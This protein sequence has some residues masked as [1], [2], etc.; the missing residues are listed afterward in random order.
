MILCVQLT[1]GICIFT[2]RLF[3][4]DFANCDNQNQNPRSSTV[5]TK[6]RHGFP[7]FTE[8]EP[9]LVQSVNW[10]RQDKTVWI[11]SCGF[12]DSWF[13]ILVSVFPVPSFHN[14]RIPREVLIPDVAGFK[15]LA[16]FHISLAGFAIPRASIFAIMEF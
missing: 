14:S 2:P 1:K 12:R 4:A 11:S 9:L 7:L 16:G 3:S 5:C 6:E 10:I 13:Q 8:V 15:I